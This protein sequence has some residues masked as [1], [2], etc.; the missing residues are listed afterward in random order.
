MR[1]FKKVLDKFVYQGDSELTHSA[2]KKDMDF[3]ILQAIFGT[4]FGIL[5]GGTFLSGYIVELGGSDELVSYL[6]LIPSICGIAL[7]FFGSFVEKFK[8]KRR[9]VLIANATNKIFL[10]SVI[11]VPLFVSKPYQVTVIFILLIVAY[12]INNVSNLAIN[13]WFISIIPANIRGR[14]FA[15]RQIFALIVHLIIPVLAGRLVD[16]SD[17]KYNGFL[18]LYIVA[19]FAAFIEQM[20]FS[21]VGDPLTKTISKKLYVKDILKIPLGNKVFLAYCIRLGF[22]YFMLYIAASFNQLY[23]IKYYKLSFTYINTIGIISVILQS[24]VFYRFWGRVNDKLGSDFAMTT[25]MWIYALD[26]L[27]WFFTSAGNIKL[28]YPILVVI[29]AIESPGFAVGSFNRRYEVIPEEGRPIY[30]AF[31]S[32]FLGI[33]LMIS[34]L[35]G[36]LLRNIFLEVDF[37]NKVQYG[38]FKSVYL[39]SS[40]SIVLLQIISFYI[41]KRKDPHNKCLNIN[42]YKTAF[43][44]LSINIDFGRLIK[45]YKNTGRRYNKWMS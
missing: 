27:V 29:G 19:V 30:D 31:F 6:T 32:A 16:L 11:F 36:N 21:K 39:I 26:M 25:S 9:L 12:A 28:F 45:R 43:R 22:F 23:L 15:V 4:V 13:T 8:R 18:I 42:N 41:M 38:N 35:V 17:E 24:L 33:V 10:V 34:P 40:I 44:E 37:I 2:A 5:T 7:I 14:Y 20:Y 1:D 3:F